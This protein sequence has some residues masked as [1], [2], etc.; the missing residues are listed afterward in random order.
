M[1]RK[2]FQRLLQHVERNSDQTV[3]AIS[4]RGVKRIDYSFSSETIVQ[5]A[6]RFRGGKGFYLVDIASPE[7]EENIDAA[8]RRVEQP[9]LVI[10]AGKHRFIG[11]APT[12][13]T[14]AALDLVVQRPQ[15]RA[16]EIADEIEV[17]VANAS[18]KLKQL[19]THGFVMRHESVADTGGVEFIYHRIA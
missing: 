19:W 16:A 6:R 13:G 11:L 17:S 15:A 3:F 8:A 14:K 2:V 7:I 9:L 10:E 18:M 5:L 12:P 1:G 4:L